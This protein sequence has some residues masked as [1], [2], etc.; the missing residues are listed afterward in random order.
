MAKNKTT[1]H[2]LAFKF[3]CS[4]FFCVSV[5]ISCFTLTACSGKQGPKGDD[6][7]TEQLGT[8]EQKTQQ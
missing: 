8:L 4:I 5:F 7:K 2:A 1:R 3:L 6:G